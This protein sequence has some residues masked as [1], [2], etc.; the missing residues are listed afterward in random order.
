[1]AHSAALPTLS[2][3]LEALL[4]GLSDD[5]RIQLSAIFIRGKGDHR[6]IIRRDTGAMV[7]TNAIGAEAVQLLRKGQCLGTVKKIL[8]K[9]YGY[10][11]ENVNLAPL[12]RSL[13]AIELVQKIGDIELGA[14]I[15][16]LWRRGRQHLKMMMALLLAE[17]VSL[18]VRFLPLP[19]MLMAL[20]VKKGRRKAEIMR[21]IETNLAGVSALRLSPQSIP[22]VARKNYDLLARS[23]TDRFLLATLAPRKLDRWLRKYTVISGMEH[24]QAARNAGKRVLLCGFHTGSYSLV[25]FILAAAGYEVTALANILDSAKEAPDRKMAEMEKAGFHYPLQIAS[26][27]LGMRRLVQAIHR[28]RSVLIFPDTMVGSASSAGTATFLGHL[29]HARPGLTWLWQK[30]GLAIMPV[31]LTSESGY[32][33]HLTIE[34]EIALHSDRGPVTPEDMIRAVYR[35]LEEIVI[36]NPSQWHR[37]SDFQQMTLGSISDPTVL[38]HR[39]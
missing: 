19:V 10:S 32:R 25:P 26:G 24:L 8:G 9:R 15:E 3:D 13:A 36:E 21:S 39:L 28:D 29:I 12:I 27:K 14:Q 5:S 22:R 23:F 16:P 38:D 34:N 30:G 2:Q 4:A 31:Y 35:K 33:H 7:K 20:Y 37:W 11:D 6:V 1:M 17:M 18:S